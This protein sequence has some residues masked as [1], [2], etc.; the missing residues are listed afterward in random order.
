M[1]LIAYWKVI[2]RYLWRIVL[3]ML[4]GGLGTAAYTYNRA[5]R[6]E[7][8]TMLFLNSA[9]AKSVVGS[10][11]PEA[12]QSL[13]NTYAEFMHTSSFKHRVIAEL[14]MPVS[15]EEVDAAL[16]TK[17]VPDTQFFRII[18][19]HSNPRLTQALANTAAQVLI[20]ENTVRQQAEQDQIE[21]QRGQS[22]ASSRQRRL[23]LQKALEDELAVRS[24]QITSL[25]AK[26]V[27]LQRREPSEE[28]KQQIQNLRQD[29]VGLQSARV[30]VLNSL[31]RA[32]SDLES[33]SASTVPNI[34]TAVVVDAAP[35]PTIPLPQGTVQYSLIASV[36]CLVL[37]IGLIFLLEYL[38]D[39][40]KNP[41][42]LDNLYG[43]PSLG[44]LGGLSQRWWKRKNRS[45]LVT[46]NE[47][48][49]PAAEMFRAMRTGVQ[50]AELENPIRSLLVTSAMPGEG[51]SFVAANL[52]VS[53]ALNGNRVI[54]VDADL[55]KPELHELF[56]LP[57]SPGLTDLLFALEDDLEKFL[58][59]SHVES[60]WLLPSGTKPLRS[61]EL[62]G[63]VR[64]TAVMEQLLDYADIIIYDSPP[65]VSVTDALVLSPQ[66]DA[67]VQVV[68]AGRTRADLALRCKTTL[69]R[70]G[71]RLLGPVLNKVNKRD[72]E[73]Y[74]PFRGPYFSTSRPA[75]VWALSWL[76]P[77]RYKL[78]R[79]VPVD[80][81]VNSESQ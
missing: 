33:S 20:A 27:E 52:A 79:T 35:L 34:D 16:T 77:R 62:L 4:V 71:A 31:L 57:A 28:S 21:A 73:E 74:T 19:V 64:V 46:V 32:E 56:N 15:E 22:V 6:Y 38:D 60:L 11:N 25:Q 14:G 75:I 10:L 44:V 63:T 13:A 70:A 54:L 5:P 41:A 2:R 26:I 69:E 58:H 65:A 51:K 40:I 67:V 45:N 1:E 80:S 48:Y 43:M 29:L 7:A 42:V 66:V 50:I 39:T 81:T 49:S 76:L 36:T 9:V 24:D 23:E 72:L 68:L 53:L 18:V 59:A 8:T 55:R 37:G 47:P 12:I 17:Y 30:N 78:N 61:A 3:L